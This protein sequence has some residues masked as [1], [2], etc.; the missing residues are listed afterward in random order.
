MATVFMAEDLKHHRKVAIKVLKPE[1][2][3]MVGAERFLAEIETTARL[4]HPHILP[5]FDSGDADSSLYYVMPYVEG[6]SLRQRLDREG[7]LSVEDAIA[8]AHEVAEALDYAHRHGIVH[9]DMKPENILLHE[10]RPMVAD[11]GIARVAGAEEVR[12]TRTGQSLG[13]PLYMSPE[14]SSG[15][16]EIDGRSDLYG[17]AS[18]LFEMLTGRPPFTGESAQAILVQRFTQAAPRLSALRP[19]VPGAVDRAVD[20]ALARDPEERH[21]TVARFA[22]ALTE[23]RPAAAAAAK[24]IAVLPFEDLSGDRENEYFGEGIAE[25]IINALTRLEGLRVA[26]RTSAFSFKG[27]REDLRAIGEKLDVAT[28]LEG[29]VRKAGNRLRVTA[30]LITVSD[31]Y[32]LWSE[33]FDRELTDVFAVQDEIA[34]AIADKLDVTYLNPRAAGAEPLTTTQAESYDLVL[35]GRS[36]LARR[37][38]ALGEAVEC[39]ERAVELDPTSARAHAG[40]GE[41]QWW[42]AYYGLRPSDEVFPRARA[43]LDRALEL[44][45]DLGEALGASALIAQ[46]VTGDQLESL[47][48]LERALAVNPGLSEVRIRHALHWLAAGEEH[49]RVAAEL[50]RAVANDPLNAVCQ[51]NAALAF[52]FIGRRD[53]AEA[54]AARA[55]ELDPQTL[56][57]HLA[58]TYVAALAGDYD[59]SLPYAEAGLRVSGRHPFIL[60][61]AT[62]IHAGRGDTA[63]A[64]AV[65]QE[66]RARAV[67]ESL[68]A[69]WLALSALALGRVDE[70]MDHALSGVDSYGLSSPFGLVVWLRTGWPNV[71]RFL[72]HPRYPEI[73]RRLGL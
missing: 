34:A 68:K 11:F 46:T 66:L 49:E 7:R 58:R 20:R 54:L 45:P 31:G 8:I 13:T 38:A 51:A 73:A 33:R 25:E 10:G 61:L 24:S 30:Q 22:E 26:A 1:L 47:R 71:D 23:R 21:A 6:E 57:S 4:Q 43:A 18:V 56:V 48:L 39:F 65:H 37:G 63:R 52:L 28:V 55:F 60:A 27:Q 2:T 64:E 29:S 35:K 14:Q 69:D 5:L 42:L 41:A 19:D 36:L 40:L 9:R 67:S 32:H 16:R 59:A 12:L 44:D 15:D 3:E 53:V 17:L 50:E 70:A 62:V 72:A